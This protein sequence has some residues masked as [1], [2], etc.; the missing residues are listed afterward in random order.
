MG[1]VIETEGLD[2]LLVHHYRTRNVVQNTFSLGLY[3][4]RQ[5]LGK[6][7]DWGDNLNAPMSLRSLLVICGA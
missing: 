5:L 2:Q 4:W 3:T 7:E 6:L 1:H